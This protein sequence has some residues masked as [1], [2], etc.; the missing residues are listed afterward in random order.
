MCH[1][2]AGS[3]DGWN[4]QRV[5]CLLQ[6]FNSSYANLP[7]ALPREFPV[8]F[9][10][11]IEERWSEFEH[12]GDYPARSGYRKK[13]LKVYGYADFNYTSNKGVLYR[14]LGHY[15]DR[16]AAAPTDAAGSRKR[17]KQ[18]HR[19]LDFGGAPEP[20]FEELRV[21]L[22][23]QRKDTEQQISELNDTVRHLMTTASEDMLEARVDRLADRMAHQI[24]DFLR[25]T[26]PPATLPD[27]VRMHQA[28]RYSSHAFLQGLC[29]GSLDG[30]FPEATPTLAT[31]T[32]RHR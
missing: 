30:V 18:T 27:A 4:D 14:L 26:P 25:T 20:L 22:E 6:E 5:L 29:G 3:S 17:A 10:S 8:E 2:A 11:R 1:P 24:L 9:C 7:E 32:A 15:S 16:V 21:A 12:A 19:P 23:K 31:A 13:L 28:S